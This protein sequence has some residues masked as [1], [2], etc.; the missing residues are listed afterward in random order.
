MKN[1]AGY[2]L[3]ASMLVLSASTVYCVSV[4]AA[5]V[6]DVKSIAERA[7]ALINDV[8]GLKDDVDHM[9]DRISS[10]AEKFRTA[11]PTLPEAGTK[12]GEAGANVLKG[13]ADRV[14]SPAAA[15]QKK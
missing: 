12:L 15:A 1:A 9:A 8:R 14:A 13:F 2:F 11:V 7:P 6:N 4:V 5:K 10:S 3:G